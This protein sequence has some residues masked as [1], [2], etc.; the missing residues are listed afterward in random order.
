MTGRPDTPT[1]AADVAEAL[2]AEP[3]QLEREAATADLVG[4][5]RGLADQLLVIADRLDDGGDTRPADDHRG[6]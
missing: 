5:L 3:E 1:D 4:E 2:A 6:N